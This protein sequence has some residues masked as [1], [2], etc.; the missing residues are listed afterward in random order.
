MSVGEHTHRHG[1]STGGGKTGFKK[2]AEHSDLLGWQHSRRS[3]RAQRQTQSTRERRQSTEDSVFAP[4]ITGVIQTHCFRT[5]A[6]CA[7]LAKFATAVATTLQSLHNWPPPPSVLPRTNPIYSVSNL[8]A[9]QPLCTGRCLSLCFA[10]HV[11]FASFL[12]A[13]AAAAS[14]L[15]HLCALP[16]ASTF[17]SPAAVPCP[18]GCAFPRTFVLNPNI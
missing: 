7:T 18:R 4:D 10:P 15:C 9:S 17:P 6:D 16:Q 2:A 12:C 14:V 8:H 5:T 13:A 1:Q 11:C 3:G